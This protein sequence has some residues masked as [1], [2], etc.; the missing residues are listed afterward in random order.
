MNFNME[1]FEFE[2]S[3]VTRPEIRRR[4]YV[5][6]GFRIQRSKRRRKTLTAYTLNR[7]RGMFLLASRTSACSCEA[8]R[9]GGGS[10]ASTSRLL[11]DLK[12]EGRASS[13]SSTPRR[14]FRTTGVPAEVEWSRVVVA[15]AVRSLEMKGGV[16][17]SRSVREAPPAAAALPASPPR[18]RSSSSSSTSNSSRLRSDSSPPVLDGMGAWRRCQPRERRSKG[19]LRGW[20]FV[21]CVFCCCCGA[22]PQQQTERE[23]LTE[24]EA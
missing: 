4:K 23:T 15:V 16:V 10:S 21:L 11:G 7:S 20:A 8:V 2:P 13:P 17:A 9:G 5:A 3:M 22:D 19:P 12:D 24:G 6:K 14:A 1:V 18:T